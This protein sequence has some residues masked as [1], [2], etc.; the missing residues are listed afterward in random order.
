[1][2][3]CLRAGG[4]PPAPL[5]HAAAHV[6]EVFPEIKTGTKGIC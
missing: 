1:M 3:S 2:G 4:E 6:F 5:Q